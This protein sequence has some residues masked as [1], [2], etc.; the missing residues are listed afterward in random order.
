MTL[1]L[2]LA[3][4]TLAACGGGSGGVSGG[5]DESAVRNVIAQELA[6]LR[7]KD[8]RGVYDLHMQ[9]SRY[10]C[11]YASFLAYVASPPDLNVTDT[12][13]FDYVDVRVSIEGETASATFV[14]KYNGA[15]NGNDIPDKAGTLPLLKVDGS[16]YDAS[17]PCGEIDG[18]SA[19]LTDSPTAEAT[20]TPKTTARV[21]ATPTPKRTTIASP[22]PT[23]GTTVSDGA[24]TV[25]VDGVTTEVHAKCTIRPPQNV[26]IDNGL[27]PYNGLESFSLTTSPSTG[28]E[29]GIIDFWAG[30]IR[31]IGN[32]V[33]DI[34]ADLQS[35]TFSGT[36]LDPGSGETA[37]VTGSF[38]C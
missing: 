32:F 38:A 1:F 37:E 34:D 26:D 8:W 16:W 25:V 11:N 13:K 9:D 6:G 20:S 2:G 21:T 27:E 31:Y 18:T 35:G 15:I 24:F 29:S 23:L 3:V 17:D 5:S 7:N 14:Q 28:E 30:D 33:G 36:F 4:V 22:T 12:S 10:S 19:L